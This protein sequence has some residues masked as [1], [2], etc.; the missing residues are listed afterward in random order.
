M[1]NGCLILA[2][3]IYQSHPISIKDMIVITI[4]TCTVRRTIKLTNAYFRLKTNYLFKEMACGFGL[5]FQWPSIG[6]QF[7]KDHLSRK[8]AHVDN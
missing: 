8:K 5:P 2:V 7:V 3:K 1:M 6:V 4:V